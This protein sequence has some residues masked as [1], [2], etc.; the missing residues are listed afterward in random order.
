MGLIASRA[1]AFVAAASLLVPVP[2]SAQT[3]PPPSAPQ[4]TSGVASA[5][6]AEQ[7]DA[8]LAQIA[9]YPDALL[10]QVLMA[11]TYPLEIVAAARWLAQG[12]NKALTGDALASALAT[13]NW[14][15]SV[16]SLLP[17]PQVLAMLDS[18]LD[19][20]QQLGYAFSA[21]Q[22]DVW[23]SIQRLR[24]QAQ[25]AG[26]LKST[27][28]QTVTTDNGAIAIA[29]A[30]PETV[31][32]PVY[33]PTVVYGSW[34]YPSYPPVYY[35]PP[36]G[37]VAGSALVAGLAFATGVAIVGSLWGW[38]TPRWSGGYGN[39]G[40]SVNVN[41]NRY[42]NINVNRPPLGQS[43]WRPPAAGGPGG[44]PGTPPRGPVGQ[45]GRPGQLPANAIGRPNVQ[46]PGNLVRPPATGS[47]AGQRPRPAGP[48]GGGAGGG[49]AQ[50]PA[51]PVG[52]NVG[53][54]PRPGGTTPATRPATR[55]GGVAG[56]P[57]RPAAGGAFN[58]VSQGRSAGQLGQR[59]AQSRS[60]QQQQRGGGAAA[61]PNRSGGGG[62]GAA[63]SAP[64]G[65]G[66]GGGNRGGRR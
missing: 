55:P 31:Y 44:R 6:N 21:Q 51:G 11:S 45:P 60:I 25:A 58:G 22:N 36:P 65:G 9:L 34:P 48:Q 38:S 10:A 8:L 1:V 56:S 53:A 16:K 43:G 20:T 4:A 3:A 46:V 13:Q 18:N 7:L 57:Q 2:V 23:N 50:R 17:F 40:G 32:V 5:Y 24:A 47:G 62:G 52:G 28:Q 26:Q 15:P 35:P 61:R 41:S 37:Y 66:G 42:N 49:A 19:W 54:N 27:P 63:R 59:G 30:S 33:N 64:R 29:P 14:D 39:W 12:N